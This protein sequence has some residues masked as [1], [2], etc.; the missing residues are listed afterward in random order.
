MYKKHE[1]GYKYALIRTM[2]PQWFQSHIICAGL[3]GEAEGVCHGDSGGPLTK[4]TDNPYPHFIQIG[5][6]FYLSLW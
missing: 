4:F 2:L 3:P 6:Y 5:Y 1:F